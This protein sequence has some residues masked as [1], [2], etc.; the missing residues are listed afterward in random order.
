[1]MTYGTALHAGVALSGEVLG[2]AL[3]EGAGAGGGADLP[4]G[5]QRVA[6]ID[7]AAAAFAV[8]RDGGARGGV[9]RAAALAALPEPRRLAAAM[10]GVAR[11]A[12]GGGAGAGGRAWAAGGEED[13]LA[14]GGAE[15]ALRW[16]EGHRDAPPHLGAAAAFLDAPAEQLRE[17]DAEAEAAT[18]AFAAAE[19]G[20]ARGW[21][22]GG[23]PAG[24]PAAMPALIEARFNVA[25]GGRV[26]VS[27]VIDRVDLVAPA[28]THN[29]GGACGAPHLRVREFKSGQQ[30]KRRGGA[31]APSPLAALA[32]GSVQPL[33]YGVA[34]HSLRT[35]QGWTAALAPPPAPSGRRAHAPAAVRVTLESIEAPGAGEERVVGERER[36]AAARRALAVADRVARGDFAP[37]P[38]EV[39]CTWCSHAKM[40]PVSFGGFPAVGAPR[41][42]AARAA[43]AAAARAHAA[44]AL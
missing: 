11:A 3:C 10:L 30:W 31:P 17:L 40:C 44:S 2:R 38:S 25:V 26:R 16:G 37:T 6:P 4:P 18:A 36:G 39:K 9:A 22:T 13:W 12:W 14:A 28:T 7:A 23:A 35:S 24:T 19:V 29:A 1:M 21:L 41:A 33:L 34:L 42:G 5:G 8:L 43:E 32:R 20:A 15:L 27:G